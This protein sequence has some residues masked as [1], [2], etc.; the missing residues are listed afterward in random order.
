MVNY[1]FEVVTH[2]EMCG[3]PGGSNAVL[4]QRMNCRQG[5]VTKNLQ[6]VS[7]T[8][9][10]CKNCKFIYSNPL[11]VPR[12]ISDH[13]RIQPED[14]WSKSYFDWTPEYFARQVSDILRFLDARVNT[15]DQA[16]PLDIGCG[17][18]KAIM[19]LCQAGFDVWGIE[20][21]SSFHARALELTGLN[22]AKV[23]NS[24]IDDADLPG[25][26]FDFV[27]FGAV[28]EHLY[29]P[30][31]CLEMALHWCK[32]GGIVHIEVPSSQWL[33]ESIYQALLKL[34]GSELSTY[35]SPMHAP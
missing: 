10:Q 35:L 19:S 14:Y 22:D 28:F 33:I 23:I 8:I 2:C 3:F 20:P 31:E 29:H 25:S 32:P 24:S 16:R 26:Y 7:V 34:R 5:L 17:I 11:P 27:T 4:G 15:H 13:Y 6:G 18:G 1:S 21:S 30:R 9:K 12:S